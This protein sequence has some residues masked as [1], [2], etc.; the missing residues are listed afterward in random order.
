MYEQKKTNTNT[1][2]SSETDVIALIDAM[3]QKKLRQDHAGDVD[4]DGK[5]HMP[6]DAHP[7]SHGLV[8]AEFIVEANLPAA[9]RVGVFSEARTFPAWIRY[10]NGAP[11]PA[12]DKK[13]DVRGMAIKLMGVPGEKVLTDE[14]NALT[15]DFLL[16]N[17]P[18]FFI[19]NVA[20]YAA[21]LSAASGGN[22]LPFFIG[23]RP[24][25]FRFHEAK[26]LIQA[27]LKKIASPLAI[28][29]WSQTPY[30]LGGSAVKYSVR[31]SAGYE[32]SPRI[33][34]AVPTTDAN[35][36]RRRM[37]AE[38]AEDD[39]C[40]DFMVQLQGSAMPVEDPTIL[41]DERSAPFRKVATIRI[42][43]QDFD[44]PEIDRKAEDMSFTP[45]HTLPEHEP[46]GGINRTRRVVYESI[47]RLRHTVNG[48]PRQEPAE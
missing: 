36:L 46:L 8:R 13:N 28:R 43:R 14:K 17:H 19:R 7:K 42:H 30:R 15:Q 40:L 37:A 16:C 27:L 25:R 4:A 32:L 35:Y 33:V 10:S 9:Y 1:A 24:L 5:P 21:F 34:S 6:R 22:P 2:S 48:V 29:Y 18:V 44:L 12:P 47:S 45:W 38:L 26:V 20:D 23:L 31:P 39:V 3:M 11:E 41:W